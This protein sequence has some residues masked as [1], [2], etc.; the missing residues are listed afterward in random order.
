MSKTHLEEIARNLY[1]LRVDDT[2]T[3]FF[4]AL[5]E[6]PDGITY[7]A[8]LL[9]TE[10]GSVLFDGWKATYTKEFLD[11][12]S[13]VADP[14][15]IKVIVIHHME[16]DHTGTLRAVLEANEFSATVLGRPMV[17]DMIKSFYGMEVN[18]RGVKDLEEIEV[19]GYHLKFVAVPWLHW[20]ETMVTYVEELGALLTCDVFGGYGVPEEIFDDNENL[21]KEYLHDV[22]EYL[23]TVIGSY[24]SHVVKNIE[25]LRNLN[26]DVKIIAPGHGLL[27]RRNPSRIVNYYYSLAKDEVSERKAVI[28]YDSMYGFIDKAMSK[29]IEI[30]KEV[31]VNIEVFK[32]NDRERPLLT[33]ILAESMDASLIVLGISTYENDL[34]P[35]MKYV[36]ELLVKK[37]NRSVPVLVISSYGWGPIVGTKVLEMLKD[38]EFK[39]ID[40]LQFRGSPE[41]EF[42]EKVRRIVFSV[43]RK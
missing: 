14:K 5:W 1:L 10:E 19:G 26:L 25:K 43:L 41:G 37:V 22:R 16:P 7:N 36:L 38:S 31:D 6:I 27:W 20:P 18:F 15:E 23:T 32:F 8:Y 11:L 34:F 9:R 33:D 12:L 3:R 30:L 42:E 13:E 4:E 21:V 24:K 28:I 2:E 35:L 29:V 17:K 40:V 39:I